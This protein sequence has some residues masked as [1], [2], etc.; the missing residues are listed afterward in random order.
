MPPKLAIIT[1]LFEQPRKWRELRY[2]P[3]RAEH[4]NALW[5]ACA[6]SIKIPHRFICLTDN[7]E[8]IECETMPVWP[9]IFIGGH[10]SCYRRLQAFDADFQRSLG[11][12]F[13]L[14]LDL[15]VAF[16]GDATGVVEDAMRD[17]FTIMVGSKY[18][19]GSLCCPY[20]GSIWLCR[21]GARDRFWRDFSADIEAAERR[22]L[23]FKMP[24]GR[25]I[26][27]SDQAWIGIVSPGE[28]TFSA[29][30]GVVQFRALRGILPPAARIVLFAG[31][32]KPWGA[33]VASQSPAAYALWARF[34]PPG[35]K[36]EATPERPERAP[37]QR[38]PRA[39]A[40]KAG[41]P[42]MLAEPPPGGL[43][44]VTFKWGQQYSAADVNRLRRMVARY[45]R[46]PHRFICVTDDPAGV[47]GETMPLW[48]EH[49]EIENPT[50]PHRPSCFRRL[51]LFAADAGRQFGERFVCVDLD[52]VVVGDLAPLWHRAEP[53]VVWRDPAYRAGGPVSPYNGSMFLLSAGA[54]AGVW[55][56]FDAIASVAAI[57]RAG[58]KGSDQAW[59]AIALDLSEATW[60]P[61]DGVLWSMRL[62]LKPPPS[63]G[64]I[65]FFSGTDKRRMPQL[66]WVRAAWAE[67]EAA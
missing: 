17:D 30:R 9:A 15:D 37:R 35:F 40:P 23:A 46:F 66:P 49:G 44:V 67:L 36:P 10:D 25:A 61:N 64:R 38:L 1:F 22:R 27:G 58:V 6:A 32:R 53:F 65:V 56:S 54:R 45:Y 31:H 59:L 18:P 48:P 33:E 7:P 19:D 57:K 29:A 26:L 5:R 52:S 24:S 42:A 3:Y 62:G 8:G 13:V 50:G 51:K 20:N 39:A 2:R 11:A 60:G 4:V 47:E 55:D 12:D 14:Q 28:R 21:A 16:S 43:T 41:A 34:A 63:N